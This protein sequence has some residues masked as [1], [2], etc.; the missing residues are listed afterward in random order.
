MRVL[1]SY[2]CPTFG[3]NPFIAGGTNN[4]RDL[5][6]NVFRRIIRPLLS[7]YASW[8]STEAVSEY[9]FP[10]ND[11]GDSVYASSGRFVL[12]PFPEDFDFAE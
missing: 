10:E 5:P 1:K 4:G 6:E 12:S 11:F 3:L 9:S 2:L 7:E 8:L